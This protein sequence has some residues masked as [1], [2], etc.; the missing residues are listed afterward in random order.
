MSRYLTAPSHFLIH[1]WLEIIGIHPSAISRKMR[2]ICY[3][4][5]SSKNFFWDIHASGSVILSNTGPGCMC[6]LILA[7]TVPTGGVPKCQWAFKYKI[8]YPYLNR[9]FFFNFKDLLN[10]R[11]CVFVTPPGIIVSI[12]TRPSAGTVITTKL[13]NVFLKF[14]GLST[15]PKPFV[16]SLRPRNAY[17]S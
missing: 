3:R 4:K 14:L 17:M 15:I 16:N 8:Y 1:C 2:K 5:F 6:D 13:H 9:C 12:C 11:S 7:I 10:R